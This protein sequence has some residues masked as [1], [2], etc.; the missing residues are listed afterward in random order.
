MTVQTQQIAWWVFF[1]ILVTEEITLSQQVLFHV[2]LVGFDAESGVSARRRLVSD[3]SLMFD[4][5][6]RLWLPQPLKPKP[7]VFAAQ[8][9]GDAASVPI[10]RESFHPH[11][12]RNHSGETGVYR[13]G[14]EDVIRQPTMTKQCQ[15]SFVLPSS[16]YDVI[17]LQ[18]ISLCEYEHH[19]ATYFILNWIIFSELDSL[20]QCYC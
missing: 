4:E 3:L 2:S 14:D 15:C 16:N 19:K 9:S 5:S 1:F 20:R 17:A 7:E 6:C 10:I 8:P 13:R 18:E 11:Q 12:S